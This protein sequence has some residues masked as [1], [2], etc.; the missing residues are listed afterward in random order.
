MLMIEKSD[1]GISIEITGEE[2]HI[3]AELNILVQSVQEAIGKT[4][5]LRSALND[6]ILKCLSS[7]FFEDMGRSKGA[8]EKEPERKAADAES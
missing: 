5:D 2:E 4:I 3:F 1:T 7:S 8:K 6:P